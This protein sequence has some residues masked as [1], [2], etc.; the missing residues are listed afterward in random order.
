MFDE[1]GKPENS[2]ITQEKWFLTTCKAPAQVVDGN[3]SKQEEQWKNL[4]RP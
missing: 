1:V 3:Q 4:R 2:Y